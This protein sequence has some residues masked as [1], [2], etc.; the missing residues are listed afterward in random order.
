MG[1]EFKGNLPYILSE[2]KRTLESLLPAKDPSK[3]AQSSLAPPLAEQATSLTFKCERAGFLNAMNMVEYCQRLANKPLTPQPASADLN[4][5]AQTLTEC[6]ENNMQALEAKVTTALTE[7]TKLVNASLE[8]LKL[9][10]VQNTHHKSFAQAAS[11]PPE[12]PPSQQ[13]RPKRKAERTRLAP[14]FPTIVLA[15][16]YEDK[17]V[18][19]DTDDGYLAERINQKLSFYADLHSSEERPLTFQA[20]RGF[21]RNRRTGD[22]TL[23]FNNQ[24]DA[25]TAAH[26][27][28]SWIPAIHNSL[29]LK[30]PSYPIIVHGIPTTFDPT[31]SPDVE[32]LISVNEGILDSLES[33]KWA[34]RHSIEA[35]KPFSSLIIHLRDPDEANKAI[36]NRLN[37]FSVLKIVEKSVRRLGQCFK[38]LGYGHSSLRCTAEHRCSTCGGSHPPDTTCPS[39]HSPTCINCVTKMVKEAQLTHPSFTVDDLTDTQHANAAHPATAASCPTRRK[40]AASANNSEFFTVNK[41]NASTHAVR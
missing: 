5:L 11:T 29:H 16:K 18:E 36:K 9:D 10:T 13:P 21:S 39:T 3:R 31:N 23:Q 33:I 22:I 14:L 12:A 27:H 41:K 34:N 7:H 25:D 4:R 17:M 19:L 37:F 32:N 1:E 26:I 28:S 40:L 6:M 24:E 30:L 20:I 15:Q 38:C 35:G 2:L 8:H